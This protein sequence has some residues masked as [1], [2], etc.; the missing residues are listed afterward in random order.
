[1]KIKR[2]AYTQ[3]IWRDTSDIDTCLK[4]LNLKLLAHIFNENETAMKLKAYA[5]EAYKLNGETRTHYIVNKYTE[6]LEANTNVPLLQEMLKIRKNYNK[7]SFDFG[8]YHNEDFP[9]DHY[10]PEEILLDENKRKAYENDK[11]IQE[12]LEELFVYLFV[13]FDDL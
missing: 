9:W 8:P 4:W 12:D 7:L 2:L 11:S 1:M 6:Y 5:L 10:S 3:P 13:R